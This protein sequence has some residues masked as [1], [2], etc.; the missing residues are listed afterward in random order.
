MPDIINNKFISLQSG[1]QNGLERQPILL[2]ESFFKNIRNPFLI[3]NDS[4]KNIVNDQIPLKFFTGT[5]LIS[6]EN[7]LADIENYFGAITFEGKPIFFLTEEENNLIFPNPKKD[8]KFKNINNNLISLLPIESFESFS[9]MLELSKNEFSQH[10]NL[11]KFI[12]HRK[13]KAQLT[14]KI[15]IKDIF[16]FIPYLDQSH[17]FFIFYDGVE[18]HISLTPETLLTVDN[19]MV[20]TMALAG[21]MPRGNDPQSDLSFEKILLTDKKNLNEQ[22]IVT[23]SVEK[24]L[25][26]FCINVKIEDRFVKKLKHVQHLQNNFCARLKNPKSLFQLIRALHPTPALG[27]EPKELGLK[28][29][30]KIE[31]NPRNLYGASVG[32]YQNN[33]ARFLVN[34]RNISFKNND[35]SLLIYGGAGILPESSALNEWIETENKMAQFLRFFDQEDV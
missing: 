4:K 6:N 3:I 10:A 30:A 18:I 1:S 11:K 23:T 15:S 17:E 34:I 19:Q 7:E 31:K 33:Y 26:E 20:T 13:I 8:H 28:T 14:N 21:T 5:K 27:G 32:F 9:K 25:N 12:L 35:D 29:I 2:D 16:H 22:S 24:T